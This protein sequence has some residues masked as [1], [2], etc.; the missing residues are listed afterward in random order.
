MKSFLMI[1]I[2]LLLISLLFPHNTEAEPGEWCV[3]DRQFPDNVLQAAVDWACQVG[4][5]D[6]SKIQPSHPCFLPNT[7]KDHASVVFNS[8]YQNY[9]HKGGTC[10]FYSAAMVTQ[11]DPS[12]D[13]CVF[14]YIP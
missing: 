1:K 11:D 12:H 7:I 5:A 13:S 8:Y 10:Y 2:A 6:C 9:K 3:A 4:G 14:E